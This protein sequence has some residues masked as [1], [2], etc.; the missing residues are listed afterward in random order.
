MKTILAVLLALF[1]AADCFGGPVF[2]EN[3]VR[4]LETAVRN[5]WVKSQAVKAVTKEEAERLLFDPVKA[6]DLVRQ[7]EKQSPEH[8]KSIEALI[9]AGRKAHATTMLGGF[10]TADFRYGLRETAGTLVEQAH[11]KQAVADIANELAAQ[12][13]RKLPT[14]FFS[15]PSKSVVDSSIQE[16][17]TFHIPVKGEQIT[18]NRSSSRLVFQFD[19]SEASLTHATTDEFGPRIDRYLAEIKQKKFDL[20]RPLTR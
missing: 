3:L 11:E 10:T 13:A 15:V 5:K 1:I 4:E 16:A 2:F 9:I 7:V 18:Y 12:A 6:G 14:P 19:S 8:A 20:A 17:I